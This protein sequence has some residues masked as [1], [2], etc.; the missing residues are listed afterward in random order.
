MPTAAALRLFCLFYILQKLYDSTCI[1]YLGMC[2]SS[3]GLLLTRSIVA[4]KVYE[5]SAYHLNPIC[6]GII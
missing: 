5:L 3:R 4:Y 1:Y 2:G 6:T